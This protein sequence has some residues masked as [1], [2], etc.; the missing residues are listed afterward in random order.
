MQFCRE[1]FALQRGLVRIF[2]VFFLRECETMEDKIFDFSYILNGVEKSRTRSVKKSDSFRFKL[3]KNMPL[4]VFRKTGTLSLIF[5]TSRPLA[6]FM[7]GGSFM[8]YHYRE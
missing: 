5:I 6:I 3:K 7:G 2:P 4:I 1:S 8:I